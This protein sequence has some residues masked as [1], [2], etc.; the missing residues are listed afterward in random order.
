M[1]CEVSIVACRVWYNFLPHTS[2][3]VYLIHVIRHDIHASHVSAAFSLFS[4]NQSWLL[5]LVF[6]QRI[7]SQRFLRLTTMLLTVTTLLLLLFALVTATPLEKSAELLKRDVSAST[8]FSSPALVPDS[9]QVATLDNM[10]LRLWNS[11]A[12][13]NSRKHKGSKKPFPLF[14]NCNVQLPSVLNITDPGTALISYG[15]GTPI[16]SP[17]E[18]PAT[19]FNIY[20]YSDSTYKWRSGEDCAQVCLEIVNKAAKAGAP[21]AQCDMWTGKPKDGLPGNSHCYAGYAEASQNGGANST[22]C[23]S[24]AGMSGRQRSVAWVT[25]NRIHGAGLLLFHGSKVQAPSINSLKIVAGIIIRPLSWGG[26]LVGLCRR[27][28]SRR[29]HRFLRWWTTVA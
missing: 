8:P 21:S 10:I 14:G 3:D 26:S 7:L 20:M 12:A 11:T 4:L 15:P 5:D 19:T 24:W 16:P 29:H 27:R 17:N 9:V 2:A 13:R 1:V 23:G 18:V 22:L 25:W 28:A 6:I